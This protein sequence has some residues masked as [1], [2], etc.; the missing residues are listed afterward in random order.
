MSVGKASG[1]AVL[2]SQLCG[3]K[4]ANPGQGQT[5]SVRLVFYSVLSCV[6]IFLGFPMKKIINGRKPDIWAT[7]QLIYFPASKENEIPLERSG[8]IVCM[9]EYVKIYIIHIFI[10]ILLY[11]IFIYI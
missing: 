3:P 2:C 6:M 7:L 10:S 1:G 11:M 5:G 9:C 8:F 4:M